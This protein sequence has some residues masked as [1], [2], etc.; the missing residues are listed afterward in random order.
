MALN[1]VP[2]SRV[3]MTCHKTALVVQLT[4]RSCPQVSPRPATWNSWYNTGVE[5]VRSF[6]ASTYWSHRL[7]QGALGEAPGIQS[8]LPC[9]PD[10][11]LDYLPK[12]DL[13]ISAQNVNSSCRQGEDCALGSPLWRRP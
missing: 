1:R 3:S 6:A 13:R 7:N 10:L 5:Q 2:S 4:T 11:L 12:H 9:R 8:F